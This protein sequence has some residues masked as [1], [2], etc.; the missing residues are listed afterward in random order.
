MHA[1]TSTRLYGNPPK[2]RTR[3][4]DNLHV[5]ALV[6]NDAEHSIKI[7]RSQPYTAVCRYK[8]ATASACVDPEAGAPVVASRK[9]VSLD[10]VERYPRFTEWRP[11]RKPNRSRRRVKT[12]RRIASRVRGVARRITVCHRPRV[13]RLAQTGNSS[14][15]VCQFTRQRPVRRQRNKYFQELS[16]VGDEGMTNCQPPPLRNAHCCLRSGSVWTKVHVSLVEETYSSTR[17]PPL[18]AP[19]P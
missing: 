6:P 4:L 16:P 12:R 8:A 3:L 10:T 17:Y 15:I 2:S 19:Y 14:L 9:R 7:A 5:D 13:V 11:R 1:E 18:A